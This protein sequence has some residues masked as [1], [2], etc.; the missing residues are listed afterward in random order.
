MRFTVTTIAIT[1]IIIFEE[2]NIIQSCIHGV[3]NI[4]SCHLDNMLN[5]KFLSQPI[6]WEHNIMCVCHKCAIKLP[7]GHFLMM[8]L[9]ASS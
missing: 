4:E 1:Y 2:H 6:L 5:N 3:I 7:P 9:R 8:N